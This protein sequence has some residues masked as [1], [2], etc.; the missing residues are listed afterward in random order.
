MTSPPRTPAW[1][2]APTATTSSGLTPL[3]GSLPLN[4]F[5]TASTTAG[6]RVMPP[7][8]MT[9]SMSPGFMPASAMAL[10][11]GSSVFAT[12]SATRSSSLAR[13]RLMTRCLGP[14]A[15]A[16]MKGRLISVLVVLD[17]SIF[18]F[19]AASLRRWR[20]IRSLE[21]S[22]PSL[23][24][25]SAPSQSMTRWSKSSPP[26]WVSPFVERTSKTPSLSSRMLMSNVPPPRS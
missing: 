26:R 8:R 16:L 24:L 20:A 15:S 13:V 10:R 11:T 6:M 21:R 14:D 19:S 2:A 5:L 1:M 25:N 9:S 18:A 4:I 7:T 17:S 12:R 22:M 3:C 23:F